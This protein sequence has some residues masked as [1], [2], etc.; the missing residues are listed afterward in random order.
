[1]PAGMATRADERPK[2]RARW[3]ARNPTLPTRGHH[4]AH[5]GAPPVRNPTQG[6]HLALPYSFS[7]SLARRGEPS[8]RTMASHQRVGRTACQ[9][10][11]VQDPAA[12]T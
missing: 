2:C 5:N 1:M 12:T 11:M 6:H 8:W 9:N 4:L 3:W 10:T 7:T